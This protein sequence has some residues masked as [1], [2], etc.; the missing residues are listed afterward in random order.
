MFDEQ[1]RNIPSC[2]FVIESIINVHMGKYENLHISIK[3]VSDILNNSSY[4]SN[5]S[6]RLLVQ[7]SE[8]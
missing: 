4:L 1:S 3:L 7:L 8:I 2:A 5:K 6:E